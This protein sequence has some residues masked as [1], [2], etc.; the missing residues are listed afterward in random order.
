[1]KADRRQLAN[2]LK[3]VLGNKGMDKSVIDDVIKSVFSVKVVELRATPKSNNEIGKRSVVA[4]LNGEI[5]VKEKLWKFNYRVKHLFRAEYDLLVNDNIRVEVKTSM[6]KNGGKWNFNLPKIYKSD[7]I[8]F[9]FLYPDGNKEIRFMETSKTFKEF[10]N[11]T[12]VTLT[13]RI[14]FLEKSPLDIF[15][16]SEQSK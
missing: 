5:M 10:G 16:R 11:R 13:P 4:G 3:K 6:M 12:Y 8:A 15:E 9:V 14:V 7:I 1:M 2:R